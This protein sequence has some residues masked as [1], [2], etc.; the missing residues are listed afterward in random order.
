MKRGANAAM[1]EHVLLAKTLLNQ[2]A[3]RPVRS[4]FK[5]Q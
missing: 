2:E 4:F 1:N 3:L 5:S